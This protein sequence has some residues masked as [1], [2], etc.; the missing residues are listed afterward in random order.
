M[1]NPAKA[2]TTDEYIE[3]LRRRIW[4]VVIPFV[5]IVAGAC[6][7]AVFAPR[8]YKASTLVLV[9]PQRVPEAFVQ[10][11]VTSKVEERLQSIAQE[12][13][14]R[15]R[16]EQ[17]ITEFRLY[18]DERK[19]LSREEV[20]ALMQKNIQVSLP[21]KKE[22]KGYFTISYIG[23]DPNV[24]TTVANRLSSLF[25]E[26]NLKLREQQAVGT[27]EFLAT[28]LTQSKARLDQLETAVTQYKRRFMG[29]LPEQRDTNLK[30][31]E[32]LQNQYQRVGE[33]LRA[34]QDRKLF[35]QKQLTDLELPIGS[36]SPVPVKEGQPSLGKTSS[37]QKKMASSPAVIGVGGS[38]ESQRES[39][40]RALE[41]LRTKY[42]ENHPDVIATKKMLADLETK[43]NTYGARIDPRYRELNNQLMMTD[44]AIK[45]LE[46]EERNMAAQ[47]GKYRARIEQTPEREQDMASLMREHNSTKESYERLLKKS[48]DAQQAENLEKRQKGEQFRVIDPARVPEKPFSPDVPKIL[49][50]SLLA[51]L[52]CGVGLAFVREQMDRSFHDAGDVEIALGLK[53][54]AT[55]PRIEEKAA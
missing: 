23:A 38:Y 36:P 39:L 10:A 17:V 53:V 48:Q 51:G 25:I 44:M 22:E 9:S 34:A 7:Y 37:M 16:L 24:V 30:L 18:E 4:L 21:T 27:T 43:K 14:S 6:I 35:I 15:T 32:Q 46:E 54:L 52:G 20:V 47:M 5:L 42:T 3:I 2:Y 28:E 29:Q 40:V 31:L 45:R 8:Q 13:M 11:T 33:S 19:S 1:I 49:L 12:V 50:I 55:I 41:D 26:E